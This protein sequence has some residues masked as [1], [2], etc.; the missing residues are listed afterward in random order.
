MCFSATA[1]FSAGLV[2]SVIGVTTIKY[3]TTSSQTMFASI[4][5]LFAVQ[6]LVE[7]F[8]WLSLTNGAFVLWRE[9]SIHAFLF[10]AQVMWPIVIPL[11]IYLLEENTKRILL[12]KLL[13]AIGFLVSAYGIYCLLNYRV[14]A[15]VGNYHV[16]YSIY[17]PEFALNDRGLL[18]ILATV[19]PPFVSSIKKMWLFGATI[20]L[21]YLI[22]KIYFPEYVISVWCFFAA[23]MSGV[24]LVIIKE[25][26]ALNG[27]LIKASGSHY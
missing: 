6:Q 14:D 2:L 10:F 1:S 16:A 3:S 7:G 5:L 8:V 15:T 11:S 20:V 17:L 22:S 4:P 27:V 24:I 9:T 23:I 19:I 26:K 25:K 12:L 13:V 18:Y 21:S